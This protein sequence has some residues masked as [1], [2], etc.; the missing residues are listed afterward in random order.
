MRRYGKNS[1]PEE[2]ALHNHL[3]QVHYDRKIWMARDPRD[4]AVSRMLYRWHRGYLGSKK[5]YQAHLDLVLK[6]EQDPGSVPFYEICRYTGFNGWP[7][8]VEEVVEEEHNRYEQMAAFVKSLDSDWILFKYEDMVAAQFAALNEYLGFA[9]QADGATVETAES[10]ASD[11]GELSDLQKA[12]RK[13]HGLQ[14][15]YCTPGILM[16]AQHLLEENPDPT[17]AEVQEALSGNLCRCTGY[18][19]II[20]AVIWA[21]GLLRGDPGAAPPREAWLGIES[22]EEVDHVGP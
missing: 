22:G 21:G 14:C 1:V 9:V 4:A 16:A 2:S 18:H 7:R 15:G 8:S 19:K 3:Q 6:K 20:Q 17:E 12:F 13:H 5:Q 10:L 11:D